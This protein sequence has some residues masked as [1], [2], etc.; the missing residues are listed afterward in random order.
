MINIVGNLKR[1]FEKEIIIL[2]KHRKKE[3][4]FASFM[5]DSEGIC[6]S[7]QNG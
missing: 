2:C 7:T 3:D 5:I 6:F 1:E 4:N